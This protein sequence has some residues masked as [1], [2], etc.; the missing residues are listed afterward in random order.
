MQIGPLDYNIYTNS[1]L[2]TVEEIDALP[3]KMVGQSPVRIADIGYAEDGHQIQTNV[4][5]VNGQRSVYTP[6][7]KQGGD[8]NTIAVVDGVKQ[9]LGRLVDVPR[10][11]ITKVVF[12]QSVFVKTAIETLL[13]EG[14]I[15]LVLIVDHDSGFPRQHARHRGG[16]LLHS[17]LGAG[18]VHRAG[19]RWK[20]GEQHGA[21]R[22]GAGIFAPHR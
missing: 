18:G 4:V 9:A 22:P 8:T 19:D 1:Q 16:I 3:I 10:S 14:A 21:G 7:L 11:L 2:S 12:D 17:A 20:L 15:G 5:R 13:H 6:V